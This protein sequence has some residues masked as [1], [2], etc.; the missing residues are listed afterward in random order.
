MRRYLTFVSEEYTALLFR[1]EQQDKQIKFAASEEN[2][3]FIFRVDQQDN[4][5]LLTL[6]ME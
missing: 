3:A 2:T 1:V 6:F 4:P 5:S